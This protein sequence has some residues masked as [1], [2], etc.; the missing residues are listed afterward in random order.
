MVAVTDGCTLTACPHC[1]SSLSDGKG[2]CRAI[3]IEIRGVYDGALLWGCPVCDL[4][5]HRWPPGHPLRERAHRHLQRWNNMGG[6]N[7]VGVT[8]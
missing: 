7:D 1:R 8:G 5:W 4:R 2:G 3:L 6:E